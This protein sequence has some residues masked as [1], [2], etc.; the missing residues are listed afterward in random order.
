MRTLLRLTM[1]A[2]LLASGTAIAQDRVVDTGSVKSMATLLQ[3]AGYKAEIKK[4]KEGQDYIVS[5]SNGASFQIL[6][7]DCKAGSCGSYQFFSWWKKAPYFSDALVNEWNR[8][9]RFL[10]VAID[11]EGDLSEYADVS[12]VGKQTYANF[13]DLIEWYSSADA[14]LGRF[15][16][17]KEAAAG[18]TAPAPARS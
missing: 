8:D 10:K 2:G 4:N 17:E 3:E 12:A 11:S 7:Y 13:V 5:G 16:S 14:E 6:F 9:H 18:K 15:L 1:A